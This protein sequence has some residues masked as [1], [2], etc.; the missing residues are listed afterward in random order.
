VELYLSSTGLLIFRPGFTLAEMLVVLALIAGLFVAG[1]SSFSVLGANDLRGATSRLISSIEHIYGRSAINGMRYQL[2]FDL[3]SN[4]YWAE[5]TE[6]RAVLSSEQTRG[7]DGN[8]AEQ[9][10][11][12][13]DEEDP[14]GMNLSALWD[15]CTEDLIPKQHVREGVRIDRVL[16]THQD[17]PYETGQASIAFFPNGFVEQSIIWLRSVDQPDAGMTLFVEPMT[18]AI[19]VERGL[20]EIPDDFYDMEEDR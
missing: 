9:L 13:N 14:F 10:R 11:Y 8:E 2:I 1:V 18:G 15:D 7:T 19:R 17:D 5:C 4:R 20:A 6:D 3:D 12:D 16:T